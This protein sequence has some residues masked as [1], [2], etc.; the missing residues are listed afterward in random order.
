MRRSNAREVE[1]MR[2]ILFVCVEN[3]G[4]SQEAEALL[5][6]MERARS[7][8]SVLALCQR[9]KSAPLLFKSCEKKD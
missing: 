8:L 1:A 9:R 4:R 7:R 5:K 3:A 2:K 6:P